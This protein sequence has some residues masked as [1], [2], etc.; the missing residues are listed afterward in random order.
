M[1]E[2][3]DEEMKFANRDQAVT[4]KQL[5]DRLVEQ[6]DMVYYHIMQGIEFPDDDPQ[7]I[8]ARETF[9]NPTGWM[10]GGS[11]YGLLFNGYGTA[12]V[13]IGRR[14]TDTF[15]ITVKNTKIHNI[16]V[17]PYEGF[18]AATS[19][20]STGI[21]DG[22]TAIVHGFFFETIDWNSDK[23]MDKN[24][25]YLG[26]T[27]TD[28][29]FAANRFLRH[30]FCP[31]GSLFFL[32]GLADWVWNDKK[33]VYDGDIGLELRCG[34]DIQSHSAKGAI[35]IRIDGVQDFTLEG[36]T[37]H[38]IVNWGDAGSD[39]CGEYEKI[40]FE[41]GVDV[42]KDIQYGYTGTK[43]HGI[44]TDYASGTIRNVKIEHL[45]SYYGSA[46]GIAMYKGS[47]VTLSGNFDINQVIAGS[48]VTKAQ[49]MAAILPNPAPYVCSIHIG[50]NSDMDTM[51]EKTPI[52]STN[53]D[54]SVLATGL[55]GYDYCLEQARVGQ[56][57]DVEIPEVLSTKATIVDGNIIFSIT[58]TQIRNIMFLLV[59]FIVIVILTFFYSIKNKKKKP[60]QIHNKILDNNDNN[61][62]KT[63]HKK[64]KKYNLYGSTDSTFNS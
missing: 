44:L 14:T 64:N 51:P 63:T 25:Y 24:G 23:L 46:H 31:L 60:K 15:G 12:V 11:S 36:I 33:S 22:E 7:W 62:Y 53:K 47:D 45:K 34:S 41:T 30:D 37:I 38:N 5:A 48:K 8:A 19:Y 16:K 10:D 39:V 17:K 1:D 9:L 57:M 50:P 21:G 6:M 59:T 32:D 56:I 55:Y 28:I 49:A 3:G 42:D 26:D 13:N 27:Y 54:F 2:Y 4:V 40:T 52:V 61:K 20:D 18:W 29:L 58:Q 35:G 43:V